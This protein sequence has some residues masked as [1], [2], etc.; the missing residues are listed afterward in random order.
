MQPESTASRP[1]LTIGI[2]TLNE[3]RR[4]ASCINSAKFADQ[5]VVVD[6]GSKDQT[7]EIA[8]ALGAE[9]HN[10]PDW[11]GFAVQ[12]NR[13]LQHATG[14]Y[15]FFLDADE[16][17]PPAMQ[18]EIEAVVAAGQDEIWEVQW[19]QVAFGKPLTLMKS[20]GGIAR[21]FKTRAIREFTGVVHERAEMHGGPRPVKRFKTRL[22]HYSRES[23]YGSLNKL[24]QYVQLGA[25]K[26]AQ[27]G[28][29][30]GVL[31]GLASGFAI[32][33]R[34]YVFRRGFMCGAEGFLFCFFIALEC[35]FRYAAI[36]YDPQSSNSLAQRN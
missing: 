30:G 20:T 2:L 34:L 25:A 5:I 10:Y 4:I 9:V 11:Q 19:N 3:A 21:M 6:S 16:E 13:V 18:A 32:F 7:R 8:A 27:A 28:K 31:R 14:E 23:I 33:L 12:R 15:V 1:R 35:F 26:R 17:M 29:T 24:A 36:K 22:L